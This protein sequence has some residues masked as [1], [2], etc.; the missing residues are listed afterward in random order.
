VSAQDPGKPPSF[1]NMG[2][3][4]WSKARKDTNTEALEYYRERS[5]APGVEAGGGPR[6]FYCMRCDGVIPEVPPLAQCPHCGEPLEGMARRYFNW[7]ELDKPVKSDLRALLPLAAG[8]VVLLLA[9][10]ALLVWLLA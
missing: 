6:N 8:G 3:D 10:A 9:V 1:G 4:H 7:V 2:P 5:K